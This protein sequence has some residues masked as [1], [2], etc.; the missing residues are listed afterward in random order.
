MSHT[1]WRSL[2]PVCSS[3]SYKSFCCLSDY[4]WYCTHIGFN[5]LFYPWLFAH[6]GGLNCS[7][8]SLFRFWTERRWTNWCVFEYAWDDRFVY[9]ENEFSPCSVRM[10]R[11][12]LSSL[13]YFWRSSYSGLC[14]DLFYQSW[15]SKSWW[16]CL[17]SCSMLYW[18]F[19][20]VLISPSFGLFRS[21]S[22]KWCRFACNL[23]K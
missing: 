16:G 23:G 3:A 8:W 18:L 11:Y 5:I 21:R 9:R 6:L 15:W 10:K 20:H 1:F 2:T 19:Y 17:L 7:L 14:F 12:H 22:Q 13:V 4:L